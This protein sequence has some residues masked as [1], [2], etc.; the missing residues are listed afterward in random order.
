LR[1]RNGAPNSPR[2][3]ARLQAALGAQ[4]TIEAE[5][6]TEH[7]VLSLADSTVLGD[8]IATLTATDVDVLACREERSEIEEAFLHLTRRGQA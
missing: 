8:A 5:G 1:I 2:L 7:F 6:G 4:A 3:G